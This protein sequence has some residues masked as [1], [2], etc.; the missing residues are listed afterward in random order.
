MSPASIALSIVVAAGLLG[1]IG[2]GVKAIIDRRG[3]TAKAV[4]DEATAT[5]VL[6]AAAREQ[7][8]P[9]R[10]EL[11][12]E[13][14]EHAKEIAELRRQAKAILADLS[15]CRDEARQL[16]ADLST[17]RSENKRL[18]LRVVEL[19]TFHADQA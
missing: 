17:A 13:R 6:T 2:A 4:S 5:S 10:K 3:L 12:L 14:E 9:L 8:D 18:R 1:A 15:E 11:A 16:R 19:E 7:V